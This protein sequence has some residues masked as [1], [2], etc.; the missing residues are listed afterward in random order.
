[1]ETCTHLNAYPYLNTHKLKKHI[2]YNVWTGKYVDLYLYGHLQFAL[3][4]LVLKSF[5]QIHAGN[6]SY[7]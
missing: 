6:C 1:M 3:L 2:S 5:F 7:L 4:D